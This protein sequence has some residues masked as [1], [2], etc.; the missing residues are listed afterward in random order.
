MRTTP[1]FTAA[2]VALLAAAAPAA[3]EPAFQAGAITVVQPWS[4]ATPGGATVAAGYLT[5]DNAGAVPDR[6]VS[7]TAEVAD[8]A[9]PHSMAMTDGV[10]R[11][12]PLSGGIVVPAHGAVALTPNGDH[13]MLEGL[14]RPLKVGE[15]FTGTLVFERAGPVAIS[16]A[17]ESIGARGPGGARAPGSMPMDMPMK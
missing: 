17:V 12:R 5:I 13:L 1:A 6:L 7:A 16:F 15:R 2:L 10:M 11:M 14:K 8:R 9:S 4:R 3:A